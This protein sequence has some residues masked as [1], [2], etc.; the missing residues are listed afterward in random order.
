VT[1]HPFW[2]GTMGTEQRTRLAKEVAPYVV[3]NQGRQGGGNGGGGQAGGMGSGYGGNYLNVG[4]VSG[5]LD[6]KAGA[7]LLPNRKEW[8][9][10][11][12]AVS[13]GWSTGYLQCYDDHVAVARF[14]PRG[15]K[16]TDAELFWL[17]RADAKEGRDYHPEKITALWDI[18][19]REDRWITENNHAGI[20][21]G[22]YSSGRYAAVETGPSRFIEWYMT[23]VVPSA[24]TSA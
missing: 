23:Q 14:T 9:H 7:P 18:T 19:Y 2:D 11:S 1:T 3:P 10:R 17:V 15:V 6:G 24:K 22:F 21:S 5:T 16:S 20:E 12:R 4:F 13:T 8:T